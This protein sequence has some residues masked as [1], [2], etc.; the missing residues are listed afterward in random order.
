MLCRDGLYKSA[1]GPIGHALFM[2]GEQQMPVY[3]GSTLRYIVDKDPTNQLL[4][5]LGMRYT[6]R[7]Q[8]LLRQDRIL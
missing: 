7:G 6:R 8:I 1:A 4:N 3:Q 5:S 2:A